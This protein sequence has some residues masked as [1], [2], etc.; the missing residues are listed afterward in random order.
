MIKLKDYLNTIDHEILTEN[1][2]IDNVEIGAGY[3]SDLLSDVMG[4]AKENQIW[5]TI[6]RHMNVIAVASM[7]DIP[8]VVLAKDIVPEKAVIDKAKD[9]DI[10]LIKTPLSVFDAAGKLFKL[11][12]D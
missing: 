9:E 5:F 4:S 11:L 6:M 3:C 10:I 2:D 7:A 8:C 1:S 12:N